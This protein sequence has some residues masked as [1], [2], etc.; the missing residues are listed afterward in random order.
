MAVDSALRPIFEFLVGTGKGSGMAIMF[1]ITGAV[2]VIS[3]LICLRNK[4]Y[5][6]LD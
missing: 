3:S 6:I 5:R 2:G 4:E 1:L